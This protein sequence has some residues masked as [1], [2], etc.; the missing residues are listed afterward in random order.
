MSTWRK[1]DS[2][3][4]RQLTSFVYYSLFS[5]P[6]SVADH[7]ATTILED[8]Q[9]TDR[10]IQ[11]NKRRLSQNYGL[12]TEYLQQHGIPYY[13]GGNAGIFVWADLRKQSGNNGS[14]GK[15]NADTLLS[16]KLLSK[17]VYL[18]QGEAF[19]GEFGW[20]RIVFSQPQAYLKEGLRRM[21][22]ALE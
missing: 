6:S 22:L 5:C 7:I 19:G 13:G 10:F 18:A 15:A 20:F 4:A 16:A 11:L 14:N 9:F 12:V 2:D 8:D 17:K 21:S 3:T 1:I